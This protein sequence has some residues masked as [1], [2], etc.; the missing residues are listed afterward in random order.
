MIA[1]LSGKIFTKQIDSIIIDVGG[2]GYEVIISSRTHDALP[3]VGEDAFLL[4]RTNVRE[5]AITLYGF[6]EQEEK[7]LFLLLN[8]VSGIGPKLALGILSGISAPE[9][10]QAIST[11]D[12][13]RLTALSGVGKKTAQ[14][15]CVEL[16]EKVGA[17]SSMT[18][19]PGA[20]PAAEVAVEG[21]AMQ[22][23]VSALVNLGYPRNTAWQALRSIQQRDPEA[24]AQMKVEELLRLALQ[25][26]A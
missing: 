19:V 25:A 8:S 1:S 14:R 4:I 18:T 15:L 10:C 13:A 3:A 6:C 21:F 9:L 26:M 7:D 12:F 11:K 22:D 17:L 5:D 23:A 20:V 24:A 16:G 2:V